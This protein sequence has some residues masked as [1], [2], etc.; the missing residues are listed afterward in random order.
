MQ[1][2]SLE[3]ATR[4]TRVGVLAAFAL[5]LGYLE[6]FIPIP[7]PGVKLGLANIAI[8]LCFMRLDAGAAFFVT[9]IK[10]LAQ[11]LL[12]GSPL[13]FAYSLT[14]SI[15]AFAVMALTSRIPGMPPVMVSIGGA[16]AHIA[17]QMV[18]AAVLLGTR[19]VWL[20]A[21]VLMVAALVT[22]SLCGVLA[23]RLDRALD[24]RA[25]NDAEP[26]EGVPVIE[27]AELPEVSDRPVGAVL[28][29]FA[30][31]TVLVIIQ[32]DLLLLSV[33]F[34]LAMLAC[35]LTRVKLSVLLRGLRAFLVLFVVSAVAHLVTY[36][37]GAAA[38]AIARMGLRLGAIMGMSL[39]VMSMFE[40]D[41]LLAF[42]VRTAHRLARLGIDTQG[43]LLALNVCLQ[44]VPVLASG[45]EP[46]S[47]RIS[48]R[49]A[50]DAIAD[51][52]ARADGLAEAICSEMGEGD[53]DALA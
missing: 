7:V 44:T 45:M 16:L 39:A 27:I 51:V 13:T 14:G 6:T 35:V 12:F 31:F 17:G 4:W 3:S 48:L 47:G 9:L 26:E 8:L 20:A 21:P 50:L 25:E 38:G 29:G 23:E 32:N 34:G 30:V 53:G 10:V 49:G 37:G 18:V 42:T 24:E 2:L 43:P 5:V 41:D 11:G 40:R 22:G 15:A 36:S 1:G 28:A 19:F 52:Y 46:G 33:L